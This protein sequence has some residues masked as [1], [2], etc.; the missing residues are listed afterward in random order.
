MTDDSLTVFE[1]DF[2]KI[3]SQRGGFSWLT[4][5]NIKRADDL[6]ARDWLYSVSTT[7]RLGHIMNARIWHCTDKAT[8]FLALIQSAEP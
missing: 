4:K 7:Q 1:I 2:L 8:A 5:A 3:T 6:T